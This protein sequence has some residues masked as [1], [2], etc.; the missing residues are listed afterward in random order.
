MF[1]AYEVYPDWYAIIKLYLL[2]W[3][4]LTEV[5]FIWYITQAMLFETLLKQS[6]EKRRISEMV[7]INM[8]IRKYIMKSKI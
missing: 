8:L 5:I 3:N 6:S 4:T 2:N 7:V 1:T